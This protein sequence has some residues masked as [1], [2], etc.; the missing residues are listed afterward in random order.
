MWAPS[1]YYKSYRL[2]MKVTRINISFLN[3]A[4]LEWSVLL[5]VNLK[6]RDWVISPYQWQ[7]RKASNA[8]LGLKWKIQSFRLNYKNAHDADLHTQKCVIMR[9]NWMPKSCC[10]ITVIFNVN[11]HAQITDTATNKCILEFF[12]ICL[13]LLHFKFVLQLQFGLSIE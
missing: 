3:L 5:K 11:Y 7:S 4:D 12:K 9:K 8:E 2:I 6:C 1:F 13:R 10:A